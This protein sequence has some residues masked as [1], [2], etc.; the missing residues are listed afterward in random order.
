MHNEKVTATSLEFATLAANGSSCATR[1]SLI[2]L[3]PH[4]NPLVRIRAELDFAVRQ[5]GCASH[6]QYLARVRSPAEPSK[7]AGRRCST[8]NWF[9]G[10][11]EP[12]IP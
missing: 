3:G 11:S 9:D 6:F 10:G 12:T 4:G 2:V 5:C 8:A 7:L 1:S